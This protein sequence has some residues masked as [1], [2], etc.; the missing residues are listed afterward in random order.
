MWRLQRLGLTRHCFCIQHRNQSHQKGF[1]LKWLTRFVET[2]I[3]NVFRKI[4]LL[5]DGHSTHTT[6]I[7][8]RQLA[9]DSSVLVSLPG[10][11][12]HPL[13]PLHVAFFRPF[14]DRR[15]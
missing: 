6:N 8:A 11:T 15:I 9:R 4:L 12:T 3:P 5:L 1:F 14:P 2:V 13:Q 7:E 10:H